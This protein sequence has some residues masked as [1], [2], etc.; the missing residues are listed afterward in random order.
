MKRRTWAV[1]DE[2]I[3]AS[4]GLKLLGCVVSDVRRPLDN[5]CP[6]L[7]AAKTLDYDA[8][9]DV[10]SEPNLRLSLS[11]IKSNRAAAMLASLL[12]LEIS[13]EQEESYELTT[14]LAKTFQVQQ[15]QNLWTKT[16]SAYGD[17]IRAFAR[18][19]AGQ[20][21]LYFLVGIRT[22]MRPEMT[23][24]NIDGSGHRIAADT[25]VLEQAMGVPVPLAGQLGVDLGFTTTQS[26]LLSSTRRGERAFA[27]EYCKLKWTA[28]GIV[29]EPRGKLRLRREL[30]QGDV[31]AFGKRKLAFSGGAD[32]D[33]ED[34]ESDEESDDETEEDNEAGNEA[35]I[36][37]V[38]M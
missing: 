21:G 6:A 20:K 8:T 32:G 34:E 14:A 3:A 35:G 18:S 31:V 19:P 13:A 9:L 5:F 38:L 33:D 10:K 26:T 23:R 25:S 17:Q 22:A 37:N 7:D 12:N 27:A 30:V 1:F 29:L 28:K 15:H 24:T 11:A 2:D 36:E 16:L 4:Q